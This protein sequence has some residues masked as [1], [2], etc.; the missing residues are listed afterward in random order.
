MVS[1]ILARRSIRK[2]IDRP[3]S[4][5]IVNELLTAGMAAPSARNRQPWH[6]III[7]KRDLLDKIP[8]YHPYSKM[9]LEAPL[10]IMVCGNADLDDNEGYLALNCA[11]A[12]QNI[13]VRATELGLGTVWLGIYPREPRVAGLRNLLN[14]P[15]HI[16]PISLI[17][18]G[19]PGESKPPHDALDQGKVTWNNW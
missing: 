1:A 16:K 15:P 10:A 13:M 9:I 4:E 14:I 17:V 7:N 19:Y 11:A 5:E 2:Y 18:V 12:T 6:F 3:V 8:E